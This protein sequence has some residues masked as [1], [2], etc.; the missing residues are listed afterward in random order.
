M[1]QVAESFAFHQN[2]QRGD[3]STTITATSLEGPFTVLMQGAGIQEVREFATQQAAEFQ[4][5]HWLDNVCPVVDSEYTALEG[6]P[7]MIPAADEALV[8]TGMELVSAQ[9]NPL[10]RVGSTVK[11]DI[12]NRHSI[13]PIRVT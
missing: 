6:M 13:V 1:E 4:A 10:P 12:P 7:L 2:N 5:H 8:D 3:Y 11:V 9:D